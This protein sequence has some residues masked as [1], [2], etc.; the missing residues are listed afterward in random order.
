VDRVRT[1]DDGRRWLAAGSSTDADSRR[2]GVEATR[3]AMA[4][5]D[6]AL[7]LVFG[8][9]QLD[10]HELLAGIREVAPGV[11]LVGGSTTAAITPYDGAADRGVVVV[12]V[13]GPGFSVCTGVSRDVAGSARPAPRRRVARLAWRSART[14]CWCCSPTA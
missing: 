9:A 5:D 12:A 10:P 2:A 3:T 14:P 11:P 13:G 6:A 8:T 4:R 1:T 7:L